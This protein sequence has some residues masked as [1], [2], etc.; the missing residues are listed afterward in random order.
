MGNSLTKAQWG[1]PS[2]RW[3]NVVQRDALQILGVREW[4][5]AGNIDE[6]RSLLREARAQEGCS[7]TYGWELYLGKHK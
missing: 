7:A 5:R 3:L 4:R 1:K 2:I 6:W